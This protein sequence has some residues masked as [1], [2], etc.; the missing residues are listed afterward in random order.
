MGWNLAPDEGGYD[1]YTKLPDHLWLRGSDGE[2]CTV[3]DKWKIFDLSQPE[4]VT[5]WLDA[6]VRQ[7]LASGAID[8][9]FVDSANLKVGNGQWMS[10][11]GSI[12]S[13]TATKWN[14]AHAKLFPA[15]QKIFGDNGIVLANNMDFPQPDGSPVLDANPFFNFRANIMAS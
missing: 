10:C 9:I 11:N 6:M 13:A 4:M 1:L 2:Y 5:R 7:P 15:A 8:G 12:P 14:A 3:H